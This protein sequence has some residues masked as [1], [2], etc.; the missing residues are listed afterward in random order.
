MSFPFRCQRYISKCLSF[1]SARSSNS[2]STTSLA[3]NSPKTGASDWAVP[4][5]SRLKYRQ[6]FN[7]LDKLMSGYLS[8]RSHTHTHTHS[9]LNKH[10]VL[11][12][13]RLLTTGLT[14]QTLRQLHFTHMLSHTLVIDLN[15]TRQRPAVRSTQTLFHSRRS[16]ENSPCSHFDLIFFYF[17]GPQVRNALIASN[18]TQT[19]LA[20]I[21]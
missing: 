7:T 2:S 20:T 15:P 14:E 16:L 5:A 21:W 3:S 6:Q 12:T 19:Q 11:S 10:E 13:R 1:L 4:Q 9:N 8:G 17:A 18:L